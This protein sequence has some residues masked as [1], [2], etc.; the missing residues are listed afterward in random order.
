MSN[1]ILSQFFESLKPIKYKLRNNENLYMVP[2]SRTLAG[3]HRISIF[4]PECINVIIRN[5]YMISLSDFK[6]F[7]IFNLTNFYE[8][9]LGI[10]QKLKRLYGSNKNEN[11]NIHD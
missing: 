3:S 8:M 9:F 6:N 1:A 5:S 4:L 10:R 11:V 7:V 2:K